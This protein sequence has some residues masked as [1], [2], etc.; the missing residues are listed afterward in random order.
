MIA[1]I[2]DETLRRLAFDYCPN[3]REFSIAKTKLEEACF[4]AK[5][6]MAIDN[7]IPVDLEA[8]EKA[9]KGEAPTDFPDES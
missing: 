8:A 2:F 3:N 9:S 1:N 6:S 7:Q 4:F 5:K